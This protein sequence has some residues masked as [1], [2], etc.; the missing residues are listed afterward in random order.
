M[1]LQNCLAGPTRAKG[2]LARLKRSNDRAQEN[3]PVLWIPYSHAGVQAT[4]SN[5]LPI[6]GNGVDL[7]EMALKGTQALTSPDIPKLGRRIVASRDDE[8]AMDL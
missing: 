7:A 5:S 1:A 8:V 4:R 3:I 6:E 2:G